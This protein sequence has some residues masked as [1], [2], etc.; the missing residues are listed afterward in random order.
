MWAWL[1]DYLDPDVSAQPTFRVV[2]GDLVHT[3]K[4]ECRTPERA[5]EMA[6]TDMRIMGIKGD[7]ATLRIM[8]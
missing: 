5:I 8:P 1:R 6:R 4:I 3:W 7:P 2:L